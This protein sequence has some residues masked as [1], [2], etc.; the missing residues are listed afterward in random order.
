[1]K[2]KSFTNI[3][4]DGDTSYEEDEND[5]V[6]NCIQGYAPCFPPLEMWRYTLDQRIARLSQEIA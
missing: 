5:N 4:W 3:V 2:A 6:H 1:M